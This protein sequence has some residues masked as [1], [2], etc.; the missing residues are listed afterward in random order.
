M[1]LCT[2]SEKDNL[3]EVAKGAVEER[4]KFMHQIFGV[5]A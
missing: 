4:I 2:C 5:A 1:K 3:V